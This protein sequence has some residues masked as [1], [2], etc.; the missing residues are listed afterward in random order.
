MEKTNPLLKNLVMSALGRDVGHG[1]K[2]EQFIFVR[3]QAL[4]DVFLVGSPHEVGITGQLS[5]TQGEVFGIGK[6]VYGVQLT[7][8]LQYPGN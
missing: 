4:G 6:R 7:S 3:E 2:I 5:T 8:H 1:N